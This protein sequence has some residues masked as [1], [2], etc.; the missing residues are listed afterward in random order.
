DLEVGV[1][2]SHERVSDLVLHLV[3]PAGTRILL[4]ESR[5]GPFGADYGAGSL[6]TNVVPASSSGGPLASTN[7]IGPVQPDGSIVIDYEFF[8]VPDRMTIYYD[9]NQIFDS[10]D[11]SGAGT[12]SVDYGPGSST[13]ITIVM[14]EGNNPNPTT[15]WQYTATVYSGYIYTRFTENTNL[16][17]TPIKFGTAP[18]TNGGFCTSLVTTQEQ[19]FYSADFQGSV[20]HEWSIPITE[21]TPTGR[22]Y[23]G[24]FN[25]LSVDLNL[26]NAPPHQNLAVAFDLFICNSWDGIG[27]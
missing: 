14:N 26:T 25:V 2:I 8:D 22:R 13:N 15:A 11:V 5:G 3:S 9:G 6:Q 1:R 20:G 27:D 12:F 18:F 21:L 23:L 17:M 16:T 19:V 10:G 24:P 7:V 4:A